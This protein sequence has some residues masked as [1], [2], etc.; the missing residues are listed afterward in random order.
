LLVLCFLCAVLEFLGD[1]VIDSHWA[2]YGLTRPP[3]DRVVGEG[4]YN[5]LLQ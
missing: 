4:S 5:K 1:K 2:H 3:L